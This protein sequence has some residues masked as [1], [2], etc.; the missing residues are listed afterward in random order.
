MKIN[1]HRFRIIEPIERLFSIG[2][3]EPGD[4]KDFVVRMPVKN[5]N[6]HFEYQRKKYMEETS[7]PNCGK[8]DVELEQCEYCLNWF[9]ILCIDEHKSE[10]PEKEN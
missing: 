7:C 8:E 4:K 6:L 9:C 2:S 3:C 1:F 5:E 10:C